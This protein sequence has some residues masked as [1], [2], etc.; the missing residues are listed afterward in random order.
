MTAKI[1]ESGV[2]ANNTSITVE[3]DAGRVIFVRSSIGGPVLMVRTTHLQFV[4]DHA[5]FGDFTED[6]HAWVEA[7]YDDDDDEHNGCGCSQDSY[8]D[9]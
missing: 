8:Y 9:D 5:D 7:F 3:D 1:I 2:S 6:K 4:N